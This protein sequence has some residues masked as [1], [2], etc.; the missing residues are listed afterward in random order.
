[1][2]SNAST[3]PPTIPPPWQY[4]TAEPGPEDSLVYQR[5]RISP[6]STGTVKFAV[7]T[8]GEL[9]SAASTICMVMLMLFRSAIASPRGRSHT[10]PSPFGPAIAASSGSRVKGMVASHRVGAL[11]HLPHKT[12]LECPVPTTRPVLRC[13]GIGRGPT[14]C[15]DVGRGLECS[16]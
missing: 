8:S 2:R 15:T 9:G 12:F 6:P 11:S 5:A 4:T 7:L 10:E 16:F 1:M 13:R 14:N 3:D